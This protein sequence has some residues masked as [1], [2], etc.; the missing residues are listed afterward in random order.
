MLDTKVFMKAIEDLEKIGIA[1]DVTIQAI[2]E[3]FESIFKKKVMKIHVSKLI[4]M[5]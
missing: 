3:A 2:K 1:H 4:L 5:K